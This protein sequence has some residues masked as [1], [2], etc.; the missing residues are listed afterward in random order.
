MNDTMK[1]V[2]SLEES[3]LLI[4]G[5]RETVKN[6]AKEQKWGLLRMLLDT[7]GATLLEN[8]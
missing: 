7:L 5:I 3:G 8:L 2:N 4:K 1:I 6:K